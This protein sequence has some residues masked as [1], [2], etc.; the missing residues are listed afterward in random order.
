MKVMIS[1][2]NEIETSGVSIKVFHFFFLVAIATTERRQ[3][4]CEAIHSLDGPI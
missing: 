4:L 3:A 1:K 2:S